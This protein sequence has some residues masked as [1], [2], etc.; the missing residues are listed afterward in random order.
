MKK[1]LFLSTV[2]LFAA[3]KSQRNVQSSTSEKNSAFAYEFVA[4][5]TLH[6]IGKKAFAPGLYKFTDKARW[7]KFV[8][9]MQESNEA[10]AKFKLEN[11]DFDKYMLVAIFD[12]ILSHGGVKFYIDK[13]E[14]TD[15]SITFITAHQSPQGQMS[16][17]VMNQPYIIVKIKKTD[18]RLKW[19]NK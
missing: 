19:V 3:C 6:N 2:I 14:N 8:Q 5:S 4:Q 11:P 17:Q 1:L 12:R 13:V 7:D 10:N 16:I 9:K 15:N 18:K